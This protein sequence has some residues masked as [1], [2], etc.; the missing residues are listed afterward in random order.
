MNCWPRAFPWL[1]RHATPSI[2]KS[3]AI[4]NALLAQP[5]IR[6]RFPKAGGVLVLK[7]CITP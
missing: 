4:S 3:L 7:P 1:R 5:A 6:A 2:A